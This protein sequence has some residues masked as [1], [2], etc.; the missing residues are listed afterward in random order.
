[1]STGINI[2]IMLS[3]WGQSCVGLACLTWLVDSSVALFI[4]IMISPLSGALIRLVCLQHKTMNRIISGAL[5]YPVIKP[6]EDG[7]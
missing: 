6:S 3:G 4:I 1:M 5:D 7:V 2:D